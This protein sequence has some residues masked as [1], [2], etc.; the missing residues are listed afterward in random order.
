[1]ENVLLII[2]L[3]GAVQGLL[4]SITLTRI[5]HNRP[6]NHF[7]AL[8]IFLLSLTMMGRLI[9]ESGIT[10]RFPNFLVLPD[11][12]IF[13]Y[14]PTLYLY[15][16]KLYTQST[17]LGRK[18]LWH[19]LPAVV[20]LLSEIPLLLDPVNPLRLSFE[21]NW[22]IRGATIEGAALLHNTF[23]WVL[24]KRLLNRYQA[25]TQRYFSHPR[26]QPLLNHMLNLIAVCLVA[27]A[28]SFFGWTTGNY[29]FF[30]S[31][32]YLTIWL[33]L[34]FLTYAIGFMAM[35][36]PEF[37][38]MPLEEA[39]ETTSNFINASEL[40]VFRLKL[41]EI[42]NQKKPHL[43]PTLSLFELAQ[44]MNLT[45]HQ[46]S[47]IINQGFEKNFSNFINGYRVEEF[48][49]LVQQRDYQQMTLLAIALEAGFN[50]KTTFNKAFKDYTNTTPKQFIDS[51]PQLF[52]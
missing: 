33:I 18:D 31:I 36:Q 9:A 32:G 15:L 50:S 22:F 8:F 45:T 29:N 4:L 20:Y 39:R 7:L 21:R 16:R 2:I 5:P 37:F 19:L 26:Y 28:Y 46:L 24:D 17:S 43:N 40:E 27:W 49:Q 34:P 30:T 38:R 51:L 1:M 12:I 23:Y 3:L 44:M 48:K 25:E 6:A 35:Y 11:A 52:S 42:M 14:G 47:K 13:L 10:N 41:E